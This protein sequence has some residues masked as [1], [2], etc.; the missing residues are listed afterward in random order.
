MNRRDPIILAWVVGLA[1]AA[2]VYVV[3]PD[4]F[5]FRIVDGLHVLAWRISEAV[6]DLSLLAL[7][8]VRALAIGLFAT[9]VVLALAVARRGGRGRGALLLVSLLF[10]MLVG[11]GVDGGAPNARWT[12]A[13]L[14]SGAGAAVMTGRLRQAGAVVPR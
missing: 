5:V 10:L 7:D 2:L 9:F 1:L 8:L 4:R 11:G 6:A 14:L 13:L 12:A 3:G